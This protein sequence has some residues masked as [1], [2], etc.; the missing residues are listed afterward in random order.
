GKQAR[1]HAHAFARIGSEEN[2]TLPAVAVADHLGT[3]HAQKRLLKLEDLLH[4][5]AH[6]K[7]FAGSYTAF[8]QQDVFEFIVGRRENA[9]TLVDFVG[10]DQVENGKMLHVQHF[11]HAFQAQAALAI[12]K[13]GDMRL[14][15][16][17]LLGKAESGQVTL[18]D[19][20]P[21]SFAQIFL[22]GAE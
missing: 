8:H 5:H 13:I 11:I 6:K 12:E 10:I 14:L 19:T 3:E 22:K 4:I 1:I 9:G 2:E 16:P 21:E 7:W 18:I 15:E 20:I 17:R